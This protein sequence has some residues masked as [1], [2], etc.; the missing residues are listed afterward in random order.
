MV[1]GCSYSFQSTAHLNQAW[2]A[3]VKSYCKDCETLGVPFKPKLHALGEMAARLLWFGA[4]KLYATWRDEGLNAVLALVAKRAHRRVWHARVLVEMHIALT[5][6][7]EPLERR[8]ARRHRVSS[9][10]E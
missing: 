1:G 7:N 10:L 9:A 5:T 4:P 3:S 2:L 8:G 6:T